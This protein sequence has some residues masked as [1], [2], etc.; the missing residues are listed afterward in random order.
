MGAGVAADRVEE[1]SIVDCF[2]FHGFIAG[3][4]VGIPETA[5]EETA[6]PVVD[7]AETALAFLS[8]SR[9]CPERVRKSGAAA[10]ELSF[11]EIHVITHADGAREH[12]GTLDFFRSPFELL[13]GGV[14]AFLYP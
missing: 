11:E 13:R 7:V 14:D 4:F 6:G 3:K 12:T 9:L 8:R 2:G 10:F 1:F 5:R